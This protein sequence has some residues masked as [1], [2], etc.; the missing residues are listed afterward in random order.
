MIHYVPNLVA[1]P[2]RADARLRTALSSARPPRAGT[3]AFPVFAREMTWTGGHAGRGVRHREIVRYTTRSPRR[4]A[5][6]AA[7]DFDFV[8]SS[9]SSIPGPRVSLA[10]LALIGIA[11]S[12]SVRGRGSRSRSRRGKLAAPVRRRSCCRR[13]RRSVRCCRPPSR[14]WPVERG[15]AA[16]RRPRAARRRRRRILSH[17]RTGDEQ[18]RASPRPRPRNRRP[19]PRTERHRDPDQ[20]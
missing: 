15:G 9:L 6:A 10:V 13:V 14:C 12:A 17:Q 2:R 4:P 8:F 3:S 19:R 11:L 20:R 7:A 1:P 16:R 18:R 5:P